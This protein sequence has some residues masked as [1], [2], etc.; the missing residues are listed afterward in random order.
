MWKAL[1]MRNQIQSGR[2]LGGR[3]RVDVKHGSPSAAADFKTR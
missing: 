1:Y 2:E 3:I